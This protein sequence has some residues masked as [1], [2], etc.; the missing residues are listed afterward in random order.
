MRGMREKALRGGYQSAS[1]YG[2]KMNKETHIPELY[3]PEI[4]GYHMMIRLCEE[5][6]SLTTI[7]RMM[8]DAGYRTRR[9]NRFEFRTIYYILANPFYAGK[10]RW[11]RAEHGVY[12]DNDSEEIIIVDGAHE[13]AISKERFDHIQEL[14]KDH[15]PGNTGKR[16]KAEMQYRHYLCGLLKCPTCG[17]NLAFNNN[18]KSKYFTCWRYAKGMHPSS[19][20]VSQKKCEENLMES[21]QQLLQIGSEHLVFRPKQITK[22]SSDTSRSEAGITAGTTPQPVNE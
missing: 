13:P 21:L 5:K 3:A 7:A 10:V 9:G 1:P 12:R 20:H 14:I 4:E 22:K 11:N 16:R 6:K 19:C 17:A 2:Y 8:N 15:K 18:A